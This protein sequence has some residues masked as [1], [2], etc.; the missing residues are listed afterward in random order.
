MEDADL[1]RLQSALR[2]V[3]TRDGLRSG[4]LGERAMSVLVLRDAGEHFGEVPGIR[5]THIF[6]ASDAEAAFALQYYR[7]Y[8][9]AINLTWPE[10]L[11]A[12][13]S[14]AGGQQSLSGIQRWRH[15]I[16]LQVLP[17]IWASFQAA[18]RSS[19]P[20]RRCPDRCPAISTAAGA[21]SQPANRVAPRFP[22]RIAAG[23]DGRP[24]AEVPRN[25]GHSGHLQRGCRSRG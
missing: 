25:R 22:A 17:A 7:K 20:Y 2:E 12:A 1:E 6:G 13:E 8:L 9:D 16:A 4:L 3:D 11:T 10:A 23:P 24:A 18:L 15:A 5:V 14:V 21:T 19:A